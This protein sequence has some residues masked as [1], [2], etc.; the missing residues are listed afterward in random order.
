M[1]LYLHPLILCVLV[2]LNLGCQPTSHSRPKISRPTIM[3]LPLSVC[4][5]HRAYCLITL[6][7]INFVYIFD[8]TASVP[9]HLIGQDMSRE[10]SLK[11]QYSRLRVSQWRV[12]TAPPHAHDKQCCRRAPQVRMW[13][14][15]LT[16]SYIGTSLRCGLT[17]TPSGATPI[18]HYIYSLS[19]VHN[20]IAFK[21]L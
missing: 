9:V 6:D 3:P 17:V 13:P 18:S 11:L 4:Y 16:P 8:T 15:K 19:T 1:W 21:S 12:S 20:V 10:P 14:Y 5:F 2:V 7:V